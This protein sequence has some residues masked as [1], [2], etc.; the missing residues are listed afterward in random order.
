MDIFDSK[1]RAVW[2]KVRKA[3]GGFLSRFA[4]WRKNLWNRTPLSTKVLVGAVAGVLALVSVLGYFVTD[5]YFN[6]G[7]FT[8]G[9]IT[10]TNA[11]V[12][13]YEAALRTHLE[14]NP[15]TSFGSDNLYEVAETD[16]ITNAVSRY[17]AGPDKCDIG[18]SHEDILIGTRGLYDREMVDAA[19][20]L[21]NWSN[22]NRIRAENAEYRT[23]LENCIVRTRTIFRTVI[24]WANPSYFS[25]DDPSAPERF[26]ESADRLRNEFLPLFEKGASSNEIA[27]LTDIDYY[28]DGIDG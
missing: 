25:A 18:I 13:A 27:A 21:S 11:D 9:G 8:V 5:R 15:G 24:T 3:T 12:R 6:H 23:R 28:T 16:L 19:F 20:G 7:R 4:Q 22:V 26:T 17:Y 14:R 2:R 1:P 10:F